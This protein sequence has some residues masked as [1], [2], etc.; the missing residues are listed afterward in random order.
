MKKNNVRCF[1]I[2]NSDYQQNEFDDLR[3]WSKKSCLE[4]NLCVKVS[5]F[6]LEFGLGVIPELD[7]PFIPILAFGFIF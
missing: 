2:I 4:F 5:S 1:K 6:K 7:S 3:K